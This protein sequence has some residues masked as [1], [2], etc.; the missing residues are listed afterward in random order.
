[1]QIRIPILANTGHQEVSRFHTRGKS[2][3]TIEGK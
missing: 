2:E 3:E 1:M